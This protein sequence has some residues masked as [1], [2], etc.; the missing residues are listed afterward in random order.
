MAEVEVKKATLRIK[1]RAEEH[2][3]APPT[4]II[5]EELLNAGQQEEVLMLMPERNNLRRAVNRA[6]NRNHPALPLS[7]QECAI[8]TPYNNTLNGERFLQ[9]DSGAA[10]PNRF[11]IFYTE[12]GLCHVCK[13]RTLFCD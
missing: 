7:L 4:N 2:P 1:R 5:K 6:Q 13:S 12:D 9:Y 11:L 3:N 8:I 10:A